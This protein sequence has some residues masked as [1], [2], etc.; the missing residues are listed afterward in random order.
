MI[1]FSVL[2]IC[3]H[4]SACFVPINSPDTSHLLHGENTNP[5]IIRKVSENVSV[6]KGKNGKDNYIL[7]KTDKMKKPSFLS[8][9]DFGENVVDCELQDL[10]SWIKCKYNIF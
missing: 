10:Q 9:K 3:L 1:V 6:R 4:F 5:D 7:F 2:I 8:I